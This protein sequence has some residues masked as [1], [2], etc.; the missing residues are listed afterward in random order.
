MNQTHPIHLR[1]G[2]LWTTM[3]FQWTEKLHRTKINAPQNPQVKLMTR[4]YSF[5]VQ[6]PSFSYSCSLLF[7]FF[8]YFVLFCFFLFLCVSMGGGGGRREI[9]ESLILMCGPNTHNYNKWC[10]P[11]TTLC[12]THNAV[13]LERFNPNFLL[14]L[15]SI[16]ENDIHIIASSIL[17]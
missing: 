10:Y 8:F 9:W 2:T 14:Y 5:N 4:S 12:T 7:L 1:L 6:H 16:L 3:V 13:E 17:H 11:L 15:L